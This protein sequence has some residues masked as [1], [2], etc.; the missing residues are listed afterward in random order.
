MRQPLQG[1]VPTHLDNDNAIMAGLKGLNT[2]TRKRKAMHVSATT[3]MGI[4]LATLEMKKHLGIRFIEIP[5]LVQQVA[6]ILLK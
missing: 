5:V 2:M 6:V 1:E 4:S 3:V